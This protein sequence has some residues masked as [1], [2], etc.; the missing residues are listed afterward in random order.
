MRLVETIEVKQNLKITLRDRGKII[1]RREGHNIW[2]N[3]GREYLA[4][5]IG[6]ESFSPLAPE[7][8][9]RIRYIGLGIGG[10]A[11]LVSPI[12]TTIDTAY[13]GTNNQTDTD[14]TITGLERPIRLSGGSATYP[15]ESGDVWVGQVQAPVTHASATDATFI[16]AF[17]GSE[18]NYAPFLSVPVSEIGLFTN[19]ADPAM[20]DNVPVAYDTFDTLSKTSS[21]TLQVEWTIK[22]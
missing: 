20:Y 18:V 11:Q 4:G 5:L 8:T 13:P 1:A 12:P 22:F 19:A 9:D 3:I 2:L 16:R 21:F 6:Y 14:P 7:R 17:T 15:G 10:T